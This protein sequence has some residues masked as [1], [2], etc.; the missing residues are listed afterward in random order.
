MSLSRQ[1]ISY[2]LI[3]AV[4]RKPCRSRPLG[5]V[6]VTGLLWS[7]VLGNKNVLRIIFAADPAKGGDG[8]EAKEAR[9][10]GLTIFLYLS[11]NSNISAS[12]KKR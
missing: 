1:Q 12:E 9:P 10:Q 3:L 2:K 7:R 5:P 8:I 6:P 4:N 11:K